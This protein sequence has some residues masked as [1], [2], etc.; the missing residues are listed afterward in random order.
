MDWIEKNLP[1]V[2]AAGTTMI[3]LLTWLVRFIIKANKGK[4]QLDKVAE[5]DKSIK[6]L[7]SEMTT[8]KGDIGEIKDGVDKQ[9]RDTAAILSSLQSIL[10]ALCDKDCNVFPARDK[11][12]D[13]LSK[14]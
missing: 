7:Q 4:E 3:A 2:I 9:A 8:I 13:Y 14:R 1:W 10:N 11:F 5:H 12:N 6:T